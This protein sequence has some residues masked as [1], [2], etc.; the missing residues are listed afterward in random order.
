VPIS[1]LLCW[2]NVLG[3]TALVDRMKYVLKGVTRKYW[4]NYQE[5]PK[6]HKTLAKKLYELGPFSSDFG[7]E[8]GSLISQEL[9]L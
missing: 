3:K 1:G 2:K 7:V 4:L 9:F 5:S 6:N 8:L